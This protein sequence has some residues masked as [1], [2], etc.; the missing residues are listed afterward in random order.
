MVR[1]DLPSFHRMLGATKQDKIGALLH[2]VSSG[3][4]R[5]LSKGVIGFKIN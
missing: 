4:Q 1:H 2:I 3:D 5:V